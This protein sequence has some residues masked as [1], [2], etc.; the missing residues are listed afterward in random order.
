MN[1]GP[2]S[3][4]GTPKRLA[5]DAVNATYARRVLA[6][7]GMETLKIVGYEKY[8]GDF[9][10]KAFAEQFDLPP[11]VTSQHRPWWEDVHTGFEKAWAE[12][13]RLGLS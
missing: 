8:N 2:G 1:F 13:E 6:S 4:A 10:Y 12:H 9:D 3:D 7:M 11:L 5:H